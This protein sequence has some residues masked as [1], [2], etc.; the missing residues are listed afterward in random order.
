MRLASQVSGIILSF[1][2]AFK[3]GR[4]TYE[5]SIPLAHFR[6]LTL[7]PAKPHESI[8]CSLETLCIDNPIS[9]SN[10][11]E[12]LS[13]AWGSQK[14]LHDISRHGQVLSITK[15]LVSALT[16]LRN[17]VSPRRLWIDQICINQDDLDERSTQVSNM[18]AVYRSAKRVVIW[19]GESSDVTTLA[20]QFAPKLSAALSAFR[21]RHRDQVVAISS[22][23]GKLG[24]TGFVL[25]SR[26]APEWGALTDLLSRRWYSRLWVIQ[27]LLLSR[28]AIFQCGKILFEGSIIENLVEDLSQEPMLAELVCR[29]PLPETIE[30]LQLFSSIAWVKSTSRIPY[31]S[32]LAYVFSSQCTTDPRDHIYGL[33]SIADFAESRSIAPDYRHT[34]S[35]VYTDFARVMIEQLEQTSILHAVVFNRDSAIDLPSWVPDWSTRH[36]DASGNPFR[37][38]TL[39]FFASNPNS[40]SFSFTHSDNVLRVK[41]REIDCLDNSGTPYPTGDTSDEE[42]KIRKEAQTREKMDPFFHAI[43]RIAKSCDAYPENVDLDAIVCDT[44]S[45]EHFS[46]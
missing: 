23:N 27:E 41:G 36:A 4:Y 35:K 43:R 44:C 24:S 29:R 16:H 32:D 7:H 13:Y 33:L 1:L 14:F 9:E 6:V 18:S 15:D 2:T 45:R 34:I 39:L 17:E 26:D 19:L 28:D 22:L 3:M 21:Q 25:P 46:E 37:M 30:S 20:V 38:N 8:A 10:M 42:D 12:A 5:P 31:F 11:H 40:G